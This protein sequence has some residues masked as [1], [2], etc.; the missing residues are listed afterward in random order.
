[1]AEKYF[2]RLRRAEIG[3]HHHI[4]V[5][6][7]LS[8]AQESSCREDNRRFSNGD[9]VNRLWQ[10]PVRAR[11][12]GGQDD[13]ACREITGQSDALNKAV[14]ELGHSLGRVERAPGR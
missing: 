5:A 11:T 9:Q 10:F 8:Y 13:E 4:A 14:K 3:I 1:M 12:A 2:F 7:L 6:Y